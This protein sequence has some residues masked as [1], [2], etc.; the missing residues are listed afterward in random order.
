MNPAPFYLA[1]AL[2]YQV[3]DPGQ[4]NENEEVHHSA[5]HLSGSL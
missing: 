1:L 4:W 5:G 3:G 2:S